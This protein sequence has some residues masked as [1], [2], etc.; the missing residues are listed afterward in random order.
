MTDTADRLIEEAAHLIV[1]AGYNGFSYANLAAVVGIRKA[2]I[3]HHFPSKAD[4]VAAAIARRRAVIQAQIA[5]LE[6]EAPD[7][8]VQLQAYVAH[9]QRCIQ[10]QSAP[11][12]LAGLLAVELPG[13]SAPVAAAVQGH[14]D[15]MGQWLLRLM[16]LGVQQGSITLERSPVLSSQFF[17]TAVYGAMLMARAYTDSAR[18][19]LVTDTFLARMRG[20]R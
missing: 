9:W 10:D 12:C 18:F 6:R 3:H 20:T 16:Q 14:F 8:L 17:Q 13:L 19:T 2:S 11:F 15:D 7:A 5:T 1:Q 4:L